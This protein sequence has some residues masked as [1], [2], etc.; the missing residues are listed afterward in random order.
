MNSGDRERIIRRFQE[1]VSGKAG[2]ERALDVILEFLSGHL[3]VP[4]YATL[5]GA[6]VTVD[7]I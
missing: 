1:A 6:P 3:A 2:E 7:G 4:A 5:A